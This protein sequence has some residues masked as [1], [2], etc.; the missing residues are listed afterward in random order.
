MTE[1]LID[2]LSTADGIRVR[3][4][5]VVARFLRAEVDPR[6][7]GRDLDVQV[8]V[9]GTLRRTPTG[10]RLSLRV[11]SVADGVQ[12]WHKRFERRP[13]DMLDLSDEAAAAIATALAVE[14]EATERAVTSA[15]AVELYLRARALYF[16]FFADM[17]TEAMRLFERARALAPDDPRI[18][19]GYAMTAARRW[20][21]DPSQAESAR[22]A[23]AA[24][25]ARAENLP[26]S[27][28][29]SAVIRYH[30]RRIPD[31]VRSLKRALSLARTNAEAHDL[32]GRI[33]S[34]TRLLA[35]S[36]SH[37]EA[38]LL[39][40]PTTQLARLM[41]A[42]VHMLQG[43]WDKAY[44]FIGN[45]VSLDPAALPGLA[46]YCLWRRD[47]TRA[48]ALLSR[49]DEQNPDLKHRLRIT[50]MMLEAV[51]LRRPPWAE[52]DAEGLAEMN[53]RFVTFAFQVMTEIAVYCDD[54]DR[55][56]SF[57]DRAD[58]M[59]LFDLAWMDACPLLTPLRSAP[60]F[61]SIRAHVEARAAAVEAAYLE[62]I[63]TVT[64]P[65]P[66]RRLDISSP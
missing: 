65:T 26:E 62:P 31:A 46:R 37:L 8:V 28:V 15:E 53:P 42:R 6:D 9:D 56:L 43:D 44:S 64:G 59:G 22:E 41:L 2:R 61:Q 63:E 34:E 27:H 13:E 3:S 38:A 33:L 45:T 50:R 17:G 12:I 52:V 14:I 58:L 24:A 16:R 60:R 40:E 23:A 51:S 25:V 7:I 36:R 5:G 30:D 21:Q 49:I 32:L 18:L 48:R 66:P 39:S 29:A 19:A 20:A 54:P 4:R 47:D 55:A 10:V 35:E 11:I 1:D 57:L